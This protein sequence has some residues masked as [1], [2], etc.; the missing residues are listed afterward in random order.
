MNPS[1][2]KALHFN[3]IIPCP[4]VKGHGNS[5]LTYDG[6]TDAQHANSLEF[7]SQHQQIRE[8]INQNARHAIRTDIARRKTPKMRLKRRCDKRCAIAAP[9]GAAKTVIGEIK[10]NPIMFT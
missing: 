4:P 10:A 2:P 1:K 8:S 6:K 9:S 3:Q 5:T 7:G